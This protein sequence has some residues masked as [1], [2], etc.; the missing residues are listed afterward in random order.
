MD[1]ISLPGSRRGFLIPAQVNVGIM[2]Y[3]GWNWSQGRLSGST[4]VL[5]IVPAVL[6]LLK[7]VLMLSPMDLRL[8]GGRLH[9]RLNFGIGLS[10][11]A[12]NV[13]GLEFANGK[14]FLR[15]QD[16]DKVDGSKNMRAMLEQNLSRRGV[17]FEMPVV[18]DADKQR[19][20]QEA[21]VRDPV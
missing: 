7:G 19:R 21:L 4:R 3:N 5:T 1:E 12:E 2:G 17:H 16:L 8:S 6:L 13:A 20:L 15:F 9:A 18:N 11:P 14:A 10:T